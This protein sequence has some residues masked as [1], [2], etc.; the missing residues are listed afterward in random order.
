MAEIKVTKETRTKEMDA[1]MRDLKNLLEEHSTTIVRGS[2]TGELTISM[3]VGWDF[4]EF[5][6]S[7]EI[8]PDDILIPYFGGMQNYL[9]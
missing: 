7:E 2:K 1:F 5:T 8:A 4:Q 3:Q 9:A 6:F